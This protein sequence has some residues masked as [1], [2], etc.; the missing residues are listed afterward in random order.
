L[1]IGI[2]LGNDDGTP[3]RGVT[4]GSLPA[5][6]FHEIAAALPP[7]GGERARE[8]AHPARQPT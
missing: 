7:A 1:L 8:V 6:L 5:R 2:W 3:M 4:G